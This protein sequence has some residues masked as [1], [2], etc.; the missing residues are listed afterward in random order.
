MSSIQSYSNWTNYVYLHWHIQSY[1]VNLATPKHSRAYLHP[2]ILFLLN[3]NA[4]DTA[5]GYW[6][7]EGMK[8]LRLSCHPEIQITSTYSFTATNPTDRFSIGLGL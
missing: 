7:V 1:S 4:W 8:F 6:R 5:R 3:Q 2:T